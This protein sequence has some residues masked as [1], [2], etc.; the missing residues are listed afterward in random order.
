MCYRCLRESE[1]R[2]GLTL[3]KSLNIINV[4]KKRI[5][6]K[7]KRKNHVIK[8][9]PVATTHIPV[10]WNSVLVRQQ[11]ARQQSTSSTTHD[12]PSS[13]SCT[14]LHTSPAAVE[15]SKQSEDNS[16]QGSVSWWSIFIGYTL[17]ALVNSY[18][19][20]KDYIMGGGN[21]TSDNVS[22][23]DDCDP[24]NILLPT[25]PLLLPRKYLN[26]NKKE[27]AVKLFPLFNEVLQTDLA[28]VSNAIIDKVVDTMR[29]Y[30]GSPVPISL[31][32]DA[33]VTADYDGTLLPIGTVQWSPQQ[34]SSTTATSN[35]QSVNNDLH[36]WQLVHHLN[37]TSLYVRP[38]ND[39]RLSQYRG[40]V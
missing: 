23:E 38:Y 8:A 37:D 10:S 15:N 35:I 21:D 11:R 2:R 20:V 16:V 1:E 7:Q 4:R 6:D 30:T 5:N 34:H 13:S 31:F 40:I 36:D 27:K 19:E 28:H 26:R 32:E 18:N 25:D 22:L 33:L 24:T 12:A 39:T 14:A 29:C 17:G 3:T 9:T